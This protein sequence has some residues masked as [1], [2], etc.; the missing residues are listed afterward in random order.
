MHQAARTLPGHTISEDH[1]L[2]FLGPILITDQIFK[3]QIPFMA[4]GIRVQTSATARS[5][6][7]PIRIVQTE[8]LGLGLETDPKPTSTLMCTTTWLR[9]DANGYTLDPETMP[10]DPIQG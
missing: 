8:R 1:S 7:N 6:P 3:A 4:G 5:R 2:V 10:A 9:A